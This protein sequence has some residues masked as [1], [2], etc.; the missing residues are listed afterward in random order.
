MLVPIKNRDVNRVPGTRV[1]KNYMIPGSS[2][3][4]IIPKVT[5]KWTTAVHC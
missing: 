2:S 1:P 3:P 4:E 5:A